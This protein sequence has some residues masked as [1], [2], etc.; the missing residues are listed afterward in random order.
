MD[1][2]FRDNLVEAYDAE[3]RQRDASVIQPWKV[4]ER[5][6]FLALLKKEHRQSLL[7][8]GSGPGR[9]GKFFMDEGFDVTCIDLSPEMVR[10][11]R[12]KGL[13]AR[14]MDVA[15]LQFPDGSF[16][17]VYALNSLLHLAKD[18]LPA[19]L[20]KICRILKPSGLFYLGVYGGYGFEGVREDDRCT[21]K[22]FF[23]FYKDEELKL[24]VAK[25][26]EIISFSTISLENRKRLHFQSVILRK[27]SL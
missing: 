9:D 17:A 23:S 24:V 27:K 1:N 19:V 13:K 20:D 8:I 25:V 2:A 11:C 5:A 26:Y 10:L 15:D 4:E 14:V 21:P 18:E 6:G 7:E 12:Q 16:D 22:R 3:A